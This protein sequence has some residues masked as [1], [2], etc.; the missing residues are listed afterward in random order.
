MTGFLFEK[1]SNKG[2]LPTSSPN[3]VIFDCVNS[4]AEEPITQIHY[5]YNLHSLREYIINTVWIQTA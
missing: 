4:K 2:S 1:Q 5:S 3:I